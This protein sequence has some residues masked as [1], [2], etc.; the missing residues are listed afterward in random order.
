MQDR[1]TIVFIRHPETEGNLVDNSEMARLPKPNHLFEPT[2]KGWGEI[3]L[4]LQAYIDQKFCSPAV[5]FHSTAQ[6][7][8]VVAEKFTSH[9]DSPMIEDS[10]LDEKWDGIFHSIPREII[11]HRYADQIALQ[12]KYGWYHFTPLG[13][14]N[15]PAVEVRIRSF[16]NDL[17]NY[18]DGKTVVICAHGNWLHLFEKLALNLRWQEVERRHKENKFPTGSLSAYWFYPPLSFEPFLDRHAPWKKEGESTYA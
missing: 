14:E 17:N 15:G 7:T 6:R 13:G 11:E 4:S 1:I 16:F 9:F 18:Y 10:R 8:R 5:I 3:D 2:E 12:E